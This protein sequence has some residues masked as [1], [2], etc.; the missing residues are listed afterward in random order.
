GQLAIPPL[1]ASGRVTV[2]YLPLLITAIV[3]VVLFFQ[4]ERIDLLIGALALAV[5]ACLLLTFWLRKIARRTVIE[6]YSA[7]LSNHVAAE[8]AG[9]QLTIDVR[10]HAQQEHRR[11]LHERDRELQAVKSAYLLRRNQLVADRDKG[12]SEARQR[13]EEIIRKATATREE[14]LRMAES[15]F[16]S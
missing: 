12:L 9:T 16:P 14:A 7:I 1:F 11:L 13:K 4:L 15:K 6:I 8:A 5:V 2:I 10:K 3:P